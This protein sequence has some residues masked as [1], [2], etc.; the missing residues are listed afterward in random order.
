MLPFCNS[1]PLQP[2]QPDLIGPRCCT[3]NHTSDLRSAARLLRFFLTKREV[4]R[5]LLTLCLLV[6]KRDAKGSPTTNHQR[7]VKTRGSI[8]SPCPS[9]ASVA[10]PVWRLLASFVDLTEIRQR[11]KSETEVSRITGIWSGAIAIYDRLHV[12]MGQ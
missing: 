6:L 12:N 7:P 4:S 11:Q 9:W 5:V 10:L 1:R 2:S 3:A 8:L